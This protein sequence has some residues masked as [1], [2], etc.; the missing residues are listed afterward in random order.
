VQ[1]RR[2]RLIK[3]LTKPLIGKLIACFLIFYEEKGVKTSLYSPQ[4]A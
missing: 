4:E 1:E 2:E 3:A